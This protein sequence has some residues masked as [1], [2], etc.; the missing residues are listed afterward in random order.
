[1]PPKR[2]ATAMLDTSDKIARGNSEIAAWKAIV[3]SGSVY[4]RAEP[5]EIL[6]QPSDTAAWPSRDEG[7][8]SFTYE[9]DVPTEAIVTAIQ[10]Q[11][12]LDFWGDEDDGVYSLEDGIPE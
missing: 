11:G 7:G 10:A 6:Y 3:T 8:R 5:V 4:T 2:K 9:D 12:G 1:M